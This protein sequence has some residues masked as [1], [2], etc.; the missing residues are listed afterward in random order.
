LSVDTTGM[1]LEV[2]GRSLATCKEIMEALVRW[3][4]IHAS[5]RKDELLGPNC[6]AK[7]VVE[8]MR[9]IVALDESNLR[10]HFPSKDDLTAPIFKTVRTN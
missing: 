3:L 7:L 6:E 5:L 8:P 4:L 2:N 10:A 1:L 9:V